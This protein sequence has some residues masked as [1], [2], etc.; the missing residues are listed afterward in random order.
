LLST[1]G[2]KL[3]IVPIDGLTPS[4]A[5]IANGSYPWRKSLIAVL[6][7]TASPTAERFVAFL[8]GDRAKALLR[9]HEY[10]PVQR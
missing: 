9:R 10:F 4:L 1:A 7:K 2:A 5:T 8:Q 3:S 6:P